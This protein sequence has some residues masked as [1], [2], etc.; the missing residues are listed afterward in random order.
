MI[1]GICRSVTL[2]KLRACHLKPFLVEFH[3]VISLVNVVEQ[4]GLD[5]VVLGLSCEFVDFGL[6]LLGFGLDWIKMYGE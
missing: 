6:E 5:L 4:F 2:R 3:V 1:L